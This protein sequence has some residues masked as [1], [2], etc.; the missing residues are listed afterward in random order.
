MLFFTV[1]TSLIAVERFQIFYQKV[2]DGYTQERDENGNIALILL[3][4]IHKSSLID[5]LYG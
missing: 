1:R 5:I 4:Q 3:N 2:K